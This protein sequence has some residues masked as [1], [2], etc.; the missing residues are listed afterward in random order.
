MISTKYSE[1]FLDMM[2]SV[3]YKNISELHLKDLTKYVRG[4]KFTI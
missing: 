2:K 3:N 1:Q 4:R